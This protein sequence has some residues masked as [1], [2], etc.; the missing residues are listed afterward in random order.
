MT[1]FASVDAVQAHSGCVETD[2]L[3]GPPLASIELEDVT[4][5]TWHL[6][7]VGPVATLVDDPHA[8][9]AHET[10]IAAAASRRC[11]RETT[12]NFISGT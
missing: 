3:P 5:D 7:G 11:V 8:R 1:Q 6:T 12:A 2:T 4:S 10:T 9:L